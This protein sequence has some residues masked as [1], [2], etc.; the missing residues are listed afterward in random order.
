MMLLILI[1]ELILRFSNWKRL[2]RKK[3]LIWFY[4]RN[5]KEEWRA[6]Y[7]WTLDIKKA[8]PVHWEDYE[9][10]YR[11]FEDGI[12]LWTEDEFI[13]HRNNLLAGRK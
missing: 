3:R 13:Y 1:D 5:R 12:Q 4:L 11:P 8:E 6:A 7:G 10:L 2:R 9:K